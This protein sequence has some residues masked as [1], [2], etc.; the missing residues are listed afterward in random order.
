M[1]G[2]KMR[3][4]KMRYEQNCRGRNEGVENTGVD[5]TGGKC[6]SKLYGTPNQDYIEKILSYVELE[7]AGADRTGW[8][9]ALLYAPYSSAARA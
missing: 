2:L 4:W 8:M 9:I 6:M 7:N 5:R 1:G 3:E